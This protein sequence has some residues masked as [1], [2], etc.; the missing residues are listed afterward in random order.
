M[1]LAFSHLFCA[2]YTNSISEKADPC[3]YLC[4]EC[5]SFGDGAAVCAEEEGER[6]RVRL[7]V[8]ERGQVRV[9]VAWNEYHKF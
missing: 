9:I 3:P 5:P 2:F 6:R 8:A 7:G 1:L 4:G